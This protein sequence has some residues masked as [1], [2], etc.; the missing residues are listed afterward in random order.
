MILAYVGGR[1]DPSLHHFAPLR[2]PGPT[3]RAHRM[4]AIR[5]LLCDVAQEKHTDGTGVLCARR[6]S[7]PAEVPHVETVVSFLPVD[8]AVGSH[9]QR[10]RPCDVPHRRHVEDE[11]VGP[12]GGQPHQPYRFTRCHHQEGAHSVVQLCC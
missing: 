8:P 2:R 5:A 4:Y 7:P 12:R 9:R 3:F 1:V 6:S 11:Q 10:G